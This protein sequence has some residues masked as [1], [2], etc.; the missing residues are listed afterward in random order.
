M[1]INYNSTYDAV[2][3]LDPE[4]GVACG[5]RFHVVAE[6]FVRRMLR[7]QAMVFCAEC[8]AR[9]CSRPD[10]AKDWSHFGAA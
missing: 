10:Y 5:P 3:G 8:Y 4:Q 1:G 7:A 9:R 2:L 6:A